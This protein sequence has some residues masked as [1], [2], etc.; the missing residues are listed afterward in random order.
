MTGTD[1]AAGI[2]QAQGGIAGRALPLNALT[3]IVGSEHVLT[4]LASRQLY[5]RDIYF[6]DDAPLAEA[7]VRPASAQQIAELLRLARVH[8]L[9]VA[10]RGG[11][12]SYT[13]GYV[14]NKPGTLT[15]DLSRLNEIHEINASDLYVTVGAAVTWQQ[16]DEA[17][18]P[19]GLR[20]V[21]KGPISGTHATIGGIASQNT[22]SASMAPFLSLEVV[23]ADGR[24]VRT[25]SAGIREQAAPF[26]RCYGP[27]LTG[28]FLGDTG[29]FGIKTRCTLSLEPIPTGVAFASVGF[30]TLGELAR[31]MILVGR[32]GIACHMLGM[33]PVNNRN[34]TQVGVREGLSTLAGVVKS[35]GSVLTGLR[36]AAA[37]AVAGQN[38]LA[39]VP[40]SLHLTV[41]GHDQ[42]AADRAL[43]ALRPIWSNA[44]AGQKSNKSGCRGRELPP[45]VPVAMRGRPFSIRGI[46]GPQGERWIPIHGIFPRSQFAEAV[47]ATENFFEQHALQLKANEIEH[48]FIVTSSGT[49]LLLEPMFYWS[50]EIG[51]LHAHV[52]G[53]KYEKF[54][55]APA[56][57]GA[58]TLVMQLRRELAE[59][60]RSLGAVHSQLGKYYE[61]AGNLQPDTYAVLQDIKQALDPDHCL[62]PG[63][64]GFK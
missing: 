46:V 24:I 4:D 60:F 7:V 35:A 2:T 38:V 3:D 58:R 15:L 12:V 42:Q 40:W 36:Q 47:A 30:S 45:S 1:L 54:A 22:G 19:R 44:D 57:P 37:I 50:D 56:N 48:S 5:S 64:L 31:A 25:G 16:L 39:N 11:G 61:F 13:G 51:P 14:P 17:L 32:S 18:R 10:P 20:S 23:M 27:D 29:T 43:A 21:M 62:N 63:N 9:A 33:D 34:A 59:L 55:G 41:E 28:L 8:G 49:T 52:L 26:S 53:S 6:W